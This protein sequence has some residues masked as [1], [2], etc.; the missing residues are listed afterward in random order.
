MFHANQIWFSDFSLW[1]KLK[2]STPSFLRSRVGLKSDVPPFQF[3]FCLKI[4]QGCQIQLSRLF[5]ISEKPCPT[6]LSV[7]MPSCS[8]LHK[9][10]S[11]TDSN[12]FHIEEFLQNHGPIVESY[13]ALFFVHRFAKWLVPGS[14]FVFIIFLWC[15][16]SSSEEQCFLDA[17]HVLM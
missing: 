4:Q 14:V 15:Q 16:N 9:S 12:C 13:M 5:N 1:S 17:Q 7:K 8:L 2:L 3:K 6:L 10:T 11:R